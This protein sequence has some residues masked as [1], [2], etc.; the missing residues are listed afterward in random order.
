MK[1]ILL[2]LVFL[3]VRAF[4]QDTARVSLLFLGD[5][6][7]H[8]SQISAAFDA[9]TGNYN[10]RPSLQYIQPLLQAADVTIGNL[11]VTLAGA[12]YKG[13]PQFSAPDDLAQSLK[14]AGVDI[15]VTANNHSMD[16]GRK[17]VERTIHLLDSID[18]KHTGTFKDAAERAQRYPF[19][20]EANGMKLALLNYTYGTNGIPVMPPN[21]VN[22]IDTVQIAADIAAATAQRPDAT[23]V[24]FH[25]GTEYQSMPN[26]WQKK[27]A[28]FCF[29]RGVRLVIG[30]H[31]HVLQPMEWRPE[32]NQLV[33]YSLGNFVSGQRVR[34]RDGG[35]TLW[36][37]L[38]KVTT[39]SIPATRIAHAAYDLQY[40]YRDASKKYYV[41]PVRAFED[42]TVVVREAKEQQQLKVFAA[43]SR[44]LFGKHNQNVNESVRY[45][46]SDSLVYMLVADS[47]PAG[48]LAHQFYHARHDTTHRDW[49][50]GRFYDI[51]TA[52]AA[53]EHLQSEGLKPLKLVR[54][55][56][57]KREELE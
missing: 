55:I 7:Q 54:L 57:G 23:L 19:V 11:E 39:D 35:A 31:P 22:L 48:S 29:R 26:G 53:R 9:Q 51:D 30:A 20:F 40:V 45:V 4:G 42:D 2:L 3:S 1:K 41:L 16:R 27:L 14:E 37:D 49:L 5:I 28:D 46:A 6:M 13:Y 8:D 56:R 44:A 10:Y 17:G 34:Y 47:I 43:D 36:V 33:A 24:F 18:L 21:I 50:I 25:W 12:P 32:N 38:E 15:L 52:R